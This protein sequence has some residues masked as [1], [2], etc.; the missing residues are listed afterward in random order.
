MSIELHLE[1]HFNFSE[2]FSLHDEI[3]YAIAATRH[4]GF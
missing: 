1:T 4:E 3:L 2:K